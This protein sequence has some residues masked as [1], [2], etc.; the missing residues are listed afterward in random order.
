MGTLL[1]LPLSLQALTITAYSPPLGGIELTAEAYRKTPVGIP[2][3]RPAV[4]IA[5]L[6]E[7][8]PPVTD[9]QGNFESM[10]LVLDQVIGTPG[11][12]DPDSNSGLPT[13]YL[14]MVTGTAAGERFAITASGEDW[15]V[16]G[17]EPQ[18][19]LAASFDT[20]ASRDQVRI[21]PCWT[22]GTF[23]PAA[24]APLAA[25]VELSTRVETRDA[26]ALILYDQSVTET[27]ARRFI[28][29]F[30]DSIDGSFYWAEWTGMNERLVA[31]EYGILPGQISWVRRASAGNVNWVLTGDVTTF[32]PVWPVPS[33][34]VGSVL[35]WSFG[36]TE[37][38]SVTLDS[39]GLSDVLRASASAAERQDEL[40]VWENQTG[41]YTRPARRFYLQATN[42]EP[43]WREVGDTVTDQ[44]TYPLEPG[45]AYTIR[46]RG[47]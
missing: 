31:D 18:G 15:V 43:I 39:G 20:T 26:D 24:G 1:S 34:I 23:M 13:Y 7:V 5:Y 42:S 12:Y 6:A 14:E 2:L 8:S 32:N 19:T 47:E 35:E 16:I 17:Q 25:Q 4:A 41:F 27:S 9:A 45:K 22:P 29:R 46:R 10:R 40:I 33:P 44:G 38:I 21:R 30:E 36:L 3:H 37:S 11:T 28:Q